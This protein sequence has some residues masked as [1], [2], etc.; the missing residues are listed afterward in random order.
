MA[1]AGHRL[2]VARIPSP[3]LAGDGQGL[4][5]NADPRSGD[6]RSAR[7]K[8]FPPVEVSALIG[9]GSLIAADGR[10]CPAQFQL[11]RHTIERTTE[12]A[13]AGEA[14]RHPYGPVVAK[15][16]RPPKPAQGR[17]RAEGRAAEGAVPGRT[18]TDKQV[19]F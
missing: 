14:E 8:G 5:S 7:A 19:I 4:P 18:S 9:T 17:L 12:G 11:G 2:G 1:N 10:S 13:D 15:S 16:A 3:R 6:L